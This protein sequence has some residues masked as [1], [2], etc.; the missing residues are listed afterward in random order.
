MH[1]GVLYGKRANL[2]IARAAYACSYA[3][4][5]IAAAV[6]VL[7]HARPRLFARLCGDDYAAYLQ[8]VFAIW[9]GVALFRQFVLRACGEQGGRHEAYCRK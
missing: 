4:I 5:I 2:T 7:R 3:L 8:G 6:L 9:Q 1:G